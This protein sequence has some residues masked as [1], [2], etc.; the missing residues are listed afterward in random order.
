VIIPFRPAPGDNLS[1]K[2]C[3]TGYRQVA[4]VEYLIRIG[5]GNHRVRAERHSR[6]TTRL[7]RRI[8]HGFP[9][10][11]RER[12]QEFDNESFLFRKFSSFCLRSLIG[13]SCQ[14]V[15]TVSRRTAMASCWY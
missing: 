10:A 2:L 8:C 6:T 12:Y 9:E 13:N 1:C 15:V 3:R 5:S 14:N 11:L 4:T 7:F